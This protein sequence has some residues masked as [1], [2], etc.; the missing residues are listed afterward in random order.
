VRESS[1]NVQ[2]IV[3]ALAR[4]GGRRMPAW[5]Q[6]E[7]DAMSGRAVALP[8]RADIDTQ[9]QEELVVEFYSR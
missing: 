2:P 6:T 5:L 9:V 8:T 1:R 4:A 7:A 3:A